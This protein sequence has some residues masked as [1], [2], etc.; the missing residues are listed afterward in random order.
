MSTSSSNSYETVYV[1]R[2]GISEGDATAIHQRV[3][4]VIAKFQGKLKVRDDWGILDLAY[5]IHKQSSG[6]FCVI[7]Y[8]GEVGVVEEIERH[9]KISG[10]VIRFLTVS[11]GDDYD[12]TKFKRQVRLAEEEVNRSRE[13][14]R[15]N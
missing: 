6:R 5:Q 10:D 11:V 15:R 7:N 1:I 9:F 3:D 8:S 14:K 13:Q 2:S 4:S 12:Y